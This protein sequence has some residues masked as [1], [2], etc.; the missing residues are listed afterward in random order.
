MA[1]APHI[2]YDEDIDSIGN[3][4]ESDASNDDFIIKKHIRM[5]MSTLQ[6]FHTLWKPQLKFLAR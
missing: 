2:I 5:W 6:S 3:N 1:D 4:V